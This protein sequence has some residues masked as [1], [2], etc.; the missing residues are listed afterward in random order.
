MST[1]VIKKKVKH[2]K[3]TVLMQVFEDNEVVFEFTGI[4]GFAA[5]RMQTYLSRA[6]R[7]LKQEQG[8]LRFAAQ[9]KERE[10]I[11]KKAEDDAKKASAEAEKLNDVVD[12]VKKEI[13]TAG[14]K[15]DLLIK[16]QNALKASGHAN[17]NEGVL[18]YVHEIER[19]RRKGREGSGGST[20]KVTS[21]SSSNAG[22]TKQV[23]SGVSGKDDKQPGANSKDESGSHGEAFNRN[24]RD[25][26]PRKKG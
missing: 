13:Y 5:G 4:D 7:Y 14:C 23:E 1:D 2:T 9:K 3:H 8:A 17:P 16:L 22:G 12:S 19:A 26:D 20:S 6:T 18:D 11:A 24:K 21:R 15:A 25:A 10:A